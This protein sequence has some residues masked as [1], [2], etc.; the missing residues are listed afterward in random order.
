M[1]N[2]YDVQ[3]EGPGRVGDMF[4]L[5]GRSQIMSSDW[6]R[7]VSSSSAFHNT[8]EYPTT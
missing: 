6:G 3:I 5:C 1:N 4:V 2:N 7:S 8:R